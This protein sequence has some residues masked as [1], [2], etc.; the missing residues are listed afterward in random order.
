LNTTV[1]ELADG[2]PPDEY[3]L[4]RLKTNKLK[5]VLD[6]VQSSWAEKRDRLPNGSIVINYER[7]E[8]TPLSRVY[9][10][11]GSNA[12]WYWLDELEE[13]P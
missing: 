12:K 3:K 5:D 1:E 6:G 9:T 13:M 2:I 8:Q 4:L 11:P 10:I 7:G